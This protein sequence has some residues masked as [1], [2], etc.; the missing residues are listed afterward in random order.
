MAQNQPDAKG[1]SPTQKADKYQEM[2]ADANSCSATTR[3][4]SNHVAARIAPEYLKR[5][6]GVALHHGGDWEL[7]DWDHETE[8]HVVH[9]NF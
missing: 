1:D 9:I 4:R 8:R 3:P 2:L 7:K 6:K 5:A